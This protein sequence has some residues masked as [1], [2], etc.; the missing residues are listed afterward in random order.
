MHIHIYALCYFTHY[1]HTRI[2]I[3]Y[4]NA[5]VSF[6]SPPQVYIC[7]ERVFSFLI[8]I[9]HSVLARTQPRVRFFF[10]L[11][12]LFFFLYFFSTSPATILHG[13]PRRGDS[14]TTS[15]TPT[16]PF[17]SRSLGSSSDPS[18]T[19]VLLA[20]YLY[21]LLTQFFPSIVAS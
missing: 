17:R 13:S 12:F 9:R 4:A 6:S 19:D 14:T 20:D 1:I 21:V 2:Q 11:S 3:M 8:R 10:L 15:I 16:A 7:S 5:S 18:G